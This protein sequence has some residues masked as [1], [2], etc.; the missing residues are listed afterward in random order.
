[1][2][3]LPADEFTEDELALR[4]ALLDAWVQRYPSTRGPPIRIAVLERSPGVAQAKRLLLPRSVP[5]VS[6]IEARIGNEIAISEDAGGQEVVEV[7]P[8]VYADDPSSLQELG[9]QD[10]SAVALSRSDERELAMQEFFQG[11]LKAE[12]LRLTSALVELVRRKADE[13]PGKTVSTRLSDLLNRDPGLSAEWKAAKAKWLSLD[14]PVDASLARWVEM[15]AAHELVITREP[16]VQLRNEN[17]KGRTGR[18][19]GGHGLA[20]D[21]APPQKLPRT[22]FGI[23]GKGGPAMPSMNPALLRTRFRGGK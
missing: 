17:G 8:E 7:L 11:P 1:M 6:W 2:G 23:I 9:G 12:E 10:D 14:P 3:S 5:L 13:Q 15:R 21:S 22:A 4:Q 16:Y 20:R 18:K 19:R